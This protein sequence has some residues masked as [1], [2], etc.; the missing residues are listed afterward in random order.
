MFYYLIYFIY[1]DSDSIKL[2]MSILV[3]CNIDNNNIDVTNV[4][5][6]NVIE[7]EY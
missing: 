2:D 1:S 3:Q 4:L 7:S 5:V 6:S